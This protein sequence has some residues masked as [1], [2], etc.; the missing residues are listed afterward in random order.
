MQEVLQYLFS[1]ITNGAIYAVIALGFSI[2]FNATELINFA[3]G[4]FVMLGALCLVTFWSGLHLPLP[5]ALVLSMAA[6]GGAGWL[7][8][9][10]AIHPVRRPD[11]IVL[12]IITVGASIFFRGVGML[13]WGKD[14]HAVPAFTPLASLEVAGAVLTSQ[15]LVIV[16]TAALLALGLHLFFR[17]TLTGKAMEACA[18]SRRAAW[19]TGIP[20]QRMILLAFVL[21]TVIGGLAGL[22]I[23]PVTMSS[24]DM[25]TV[26]GLKG[27]CAAMLGGLG[28]LWG[29]VLGGLLL[30]VLESLS[31][32]LVNSG[33][34]DATAFLLLLAILY[35]RP[36][37]LLG[38]RSVQRF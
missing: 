33:L 25:G 29:A 20:A 10:L 21:S 27:F 3:H 34:K 19:L 32:G 2:L 5:L 28:S 17:R 4:E 15:S 11:H 9:R 23:A 14:A 12:V 30:G 6:V 38:N 8:Q 1:G 22:I 18:I 16:A 13:V 36:S 24:Y 35:A 37:G 31:V 7:F 26:L